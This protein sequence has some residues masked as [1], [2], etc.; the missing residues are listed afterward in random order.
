MERY[1]LSELLTIKNGKDYKH[2]NNGVFPVYGSGG[3]MCY[4][5]DYIYDKPS[6]LLPRKGTLTNIQ[7]CDKPFWSVD[8]CFYSIVNTNKVDTY[9]LYRY[10]RYLDLSGLDTGASIPS[11]TIKSYYGIKVSLPSLPLQRRIASILSAYDTLIDLNTRRIRI[12]E[13]MAEHLYREWFVRFRFPNHENTP[14]VDGLPQ[15]W[16]VEKLGNYADIIMGQSPESKYYNTDQKGLPFHQGVGSYGEY[17]LKDD[18]YSTEGKKIA[19]PFS[20]IFSVRAPVGRININLTKIILGRGVAAINAKDGHNHFLLR[21]LKYL[22][23]KEDTIGNGSIFACVNKEE[24]QKQKLTIP[25]Q[26]TLA[27]FDYIANYFEQEIRVLTLQSSLLA[28][29]R[30][31]LLPRLLN[32]KIEVGE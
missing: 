18:I 29:Q 31:L 5:D 16:R 32:G 27:K 8:T 14:I 4:V 19:E 10:L 20:I 15:G 25:D 7:Y 9:Y 21:Q 30:D 13:Q 6:V 1:K 24:L 17:Y 23:Q 22:F 28:R 12:L 3:V 26:Q 2:L 11:M